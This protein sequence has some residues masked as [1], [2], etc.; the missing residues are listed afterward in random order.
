MHLREVLFSNSVNMNSGTT[1]YGSGEMKGW[2][3]TS[4]LICMIGPLPL[5]LI[6]KLESYLVQHRQLTSTLRELIYHLL[7][8]TKVNY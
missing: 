8:T 1:I 5:L 7:F 4:F 2:G 6:V 3:Q